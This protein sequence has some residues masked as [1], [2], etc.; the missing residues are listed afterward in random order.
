MDKSV[1]I[2]HVGPRQPAESFIALEKPP[3]GDRQS[4]GTIAQAEGRIID[5]LPVQLPEHRAHL[6]G[7]QPASPLWRGGHGHRVEVVQKGSKTRY[8][9]RRLDDVIEVERSPQ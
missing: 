7:C 6:L 5:V 4:I 3:V 2:P 1:F 9:R 8:G